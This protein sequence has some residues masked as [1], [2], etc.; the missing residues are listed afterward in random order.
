MGDGGVW[1]GVGLGERA[2]EKAG[3]KVLLGFCE[4]HAWQWRE[5]TAIGWFIYSLIYLLSIM[6]LGLELS[7]D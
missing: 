4:D 5:S 1:A 7:D 3:E 6:K 2:P